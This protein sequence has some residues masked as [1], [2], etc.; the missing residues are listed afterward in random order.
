MTTTT[1]GRRLYARHG[2][3]LIELMIAIAIFGI[4]AAGAFLA[5]NAFFGT[6]RETGTQQRLASLKLAITQFNLNT[7][8]YPRT[9]KDLAVKPT[10]EPT[11]ASKWKGPYVETEKPYDLDAWDNKFVYKVTPGAK[12]PYELYSYGEVGD[13]TAPVE[14]RI[15]VW[16]Q[17]RK[18]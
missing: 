15:S 3:T 5:Y 2:F 17:E 11:L 18:E 16:G 6:A 12:R 4:L 8:K 7:G 1:T 14:D 13:S 10:D 9:L